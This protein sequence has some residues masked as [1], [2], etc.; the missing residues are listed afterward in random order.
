[1]M[2]SRLTA[3]LDWVRKNGAGTGLEVLINGVAPF[4]IY[5]LTDARLG[6]VGALIASSVPPIAWSALEFLRHRRVDALSILVLSGIA[7]S[8]LAVLGGG[9]A[10]WLQLRENLVTGAIG[11]VFLASAAIG[12]PLIFYLARATMLRTSP[13]EAAS[14]DQM[15]E[16]ARFKRTM[17]VMTLVWGAG[18]IARTAVSVVLVFSL[19]IP[20][21]L[22][23]HPI[24]GYAT[25]GALALWTVWYTGRQRRLGAAE[26]AAREA[27]EAAASSQAAPATAAGG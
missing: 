1:M 21:Y 2:A 22:I 23:A 5:T 14:F 3:I 13:S 4:V 11:L 12:R 20:N 8:L 24:V 25:M 26:R 18:L 19:T 27:A 15:K 17:M 6:D 10:K 9:G 7:F 16:Y